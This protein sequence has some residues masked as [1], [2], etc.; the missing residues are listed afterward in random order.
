MKTQKAH[1]IEETIQQISVSELD[2]IIS[3]SSHT[4]IDVRDKKTIE[5]QGSIPGAVNIPFD[6]V[7]S[8]LDQRH[9]ESS[10]IFNG[11]G[12][13]LF[14]CVGGGMS[15]KAATKAQEKGIK[16]V[17]NLDGGHSSWIKLKTVAA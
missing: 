3:K 16:N 12:P 9:E 10:S 5:A 1:A 14:C 17:C 15:F 13:Y 6:T 8:V 4:I 11:E 2:E 7:E